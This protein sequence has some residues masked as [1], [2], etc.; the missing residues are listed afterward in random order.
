MMKKAVA[1]SLMLTNVFA[2][3][4]LMETQTSLPSGFKWGERA[5]AEEI[6]LIF[7]VKQQNLDKLHDTLMAVSDPDSPSYG[8]HLSNEEVHDLVRPSKV[9]AE[10]VENF[11]RS[12]GHEP[13]S[14]TP[15]GDFL[16]VDVTIQEAENLLNAEYRYVEHE[17][18]DFK[19]VRTSQYSLP[20]E[21][22]RGTL[23]LPTS[24][25]THTHTHTHTQPW[26]LFPRLFTFLLHQNHNLFWKTLHH[27]L[28]T[29]QNIFV[30]STAW[31]W[32]VK[33]KTTRWQSRHF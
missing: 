12:Q 8:D 13:I 25:H 27:C 5:N 9:D 11:L 21:V 23:I 33:P 18:S 3:N 10:I 28:E 30:I 6:E 4:M 24:L 29:R 22:S 17:E 31:T 19:V 1:A 16:K 26:T 20:E 2:D 15:N 7:A 14:L 32:R